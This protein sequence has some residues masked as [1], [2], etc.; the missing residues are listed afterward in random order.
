MKIPRCPHRWNVSPKRAVEIQ[1]ELSSRVRIE[2]FVGPIEIVAGLDIAFSKDKSHA[3]AGIVVWH[4][5]RHEVIEEVV[6][7]EPV[8][9]PYVPG[10]LSFREGPALIKAIRKLRHNPDVFMFDG[11]GY[12][13][14]RRF[15]LACHIGVIIDKPSI[16]CGKSRLV[17]QHSTPASKRGS[18]TVLKHNSETIGCVL[19]TKN[20]VKPVYISVGHR[21]A[22]QQATSIVK[23]CTTC[24]R[25]PEPTRLADRL[26][27]NAKHSAK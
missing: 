16:G 4:V 25:L 13:H 18:Q 22:L 19:R 15:G 12:A 5:H 6:V 7:R 20:N 8:R 21:V 9:F 27:A 11:Q 1:R 2:P 3:I 26:V 14:P 24:Y 17:G 10:L 23:K